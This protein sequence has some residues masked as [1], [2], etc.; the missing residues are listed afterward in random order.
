MGKSQHCQSN[1]NQNSQEGARILRKKLFITLCIFITLC[2]Y[3]CFEKVNTVPTPAMEINLEKVILSTD[4]NG[5]EGVSTFNMSD[6][7]IYLLF[8]A[9]NLPADTQIRSEWFFINTEE[10]KED[11]TG[12]FNIK[13][14]STMKSGSFTFN[15]PAEGW[16][17]GEY[18]VKLYFNEKLMKNISF[19]IE[20]PTV[21]EEPEDQK[22]TDIEPMSLFYLKTSIKEQDKKSKFSVFINDEETGDIE[23]DTQINISSKLHKGENSVTITSNIEETLSSNIK[24]TIE[25]IWRNKRFPILIHRRKDKGED[26]VKYKLDIPDISKINYPLLKEEYNLKTDMGNGTPETVFNII[27]NGFPIGSYSDSVN[28]DVTPFIKTGENEIKITGELDKNLSGRVTL[29]LGSLRWGKMSPILTHSRKKAGVALSVY[30][31]NIPD[32]TAIKNKI[33]E[34]TYILKTDMAKGTDGTKFEI[35][36]NDIQT[37]IFNSD[38][39]VDITHYLKEGLNKVEIKSDIEEELSSDIIASIVT[40]KK[41]QWKTLMKHTAIK[42]GNSVKVYD[43]IVPQETSTIPQC[44]MRVDMTGKKEETSFNIYIN[45]YI[46]GGFET[47]TSIDITGF[48][49]E[50][51]NKVRIESKIPQDL[52]KEVTAGIG[53]YKNGAWNTLLTHSKSRKGNYKDEYTVMIK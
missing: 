12:E 35:F 19:T 26:T 21:A 22:D 11:K 4:R 32:I 50:G 27:I 38:T 53:S 18:K 17:G 5:N 28:L 29:T 24:L 25:A 20:S 8:E 9:N 34:D 16:K 33:P 3:G 47:N 7:N 14:G 52:D 1:K 49:K 43:L 30:K 48:M 6:K 46:V 44:T 37:G 13:A 42:K 2:F 36:I 51:A 15:R 40:D 45:D 23:T 10:G 39:T 41:G 31:I